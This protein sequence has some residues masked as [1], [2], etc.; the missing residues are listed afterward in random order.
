MNIKN[1]IDE[2]LS[3]HDSIMA[4]AEGSEFKQEEIVS[5][6]SEG[7]ISIYKK[8]YNTQDNVQV[9]IG[10]GDVYLL[11]T[12]KVVDKVVLDGMQI[13]LEDALKIDPSIKLGNEIEI[14]EHP[15]DYGRQY[16]YS[17]F[18][19]VKSRLNQLKFQKI[20]DEYDKKIG[21]LILGY[22][23]RRRG[24]TIYMDIGSFEA[25]MPVKAQIPKERL[26]PEDKVK[27]LLRSVEMDPRG[28]GLKVVVSRADKRF[29]EKLFEME[30]PEIHDGTVK[31]L[32]IARIP[33]VRTKVIVSTEREEVDPVG[34]CVGLRG[35]RIQSI[36]RELGHE[37]ID[38][39][40]YDEDLKTFIGKA[41]SPAKCLYIQINEESKS[42]LVVIPDADLPTAIGK[43]GSNVKLTS[44]IVQYS[45][46]LKPES[47]FS[48]DDYES[49]AKK[50]LDALFS[51]KEESV[52]DLSETSSS[53]DAIADGETPLEELLS[54]SKRIIGILND[55][56]IYSLE[57]LIAL[58]LEDLEKID[59]IGK[60]TAKIIMEMILENVEF[61]EEENIV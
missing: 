18:Q 7:L 27:V 15:Q 50:N 47:S 35:V 42:A 32:T 6:I 56:G 19:L 14:E 41:F 17:A 48:A 26:R 3:F 28:H 36:V 45:I 60:T 39:V 23:V 8:K 29:I 40:P 31:I 58:E 34:A 2:S 33:G 54:L 11:A 55:A 49:D 43:D 52:E 25:I 24:D 57:T 44:Q 53:E 20:K 51:L 22:V 9:I 38:I 46:D 13:A 30:V 1:N 12:K 37:R 59:G 16:M 10:D 5:I 4:L 61:E 21:E